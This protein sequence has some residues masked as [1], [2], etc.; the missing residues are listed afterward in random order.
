MNQPDFI[1]IG[2]G[3][4]GCILALRLARDFGATVTLIEAPSQPAPMID[5]ERPVRWMRLLESSE[6]W[7][8]STQPAKTLANR[9]LRWPRGRG[10]GGSSRINAM[11]WFPPTLADMTKLSAATNGYWSTDRIR[12]SLQA[13][14]DL[15]Q[16][17]KPGWLSLASQAFLDA[18]SKIPA[19]TP[20]AYQRIQNQGKRTSL[21]AILGYQ[22]DRVECASPFSASGQ[23]GSPQSIHYGIQVVRGLVNRI[24][25]RD[26]RAIGVTLETEQGKGEI[27]CN[28]GVILAAGS[29]S[30]PAI[31]MRSGVGSKELLNEIGIPIRND[32]PSVG[33]RLY[34]HLIMPVIFQQKQSRHQFSIQASP[35]DLSRWQMLGTGPLASNLAECGGLFLAN[36]I[37][38]HVTPTHYLTFPKLDDAAW[39]SIGVN[40]TQPKSHGHLRITSANPLDPPEIEAGYF[41]CEQD[42]ELMLQGIELTRE[43]ATMKSL[44]NL[45]DHESL[46]GDKRKSAQVLTRTIQ[47]FA[48][49][50]Y[51]PVGSCS[52]GTNETDV[53]DHRFRLRHSEGI[54]V[55]DGSVLPGIT[56]GNPSATI[57]SLAWMASEEIA[58][59]VE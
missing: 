27:S 37:Q 58:S 23:S 48:Q 44:D 21:A 14:T 8:F 22:E 34:D 56:L 19:A 42:F 51:H 26:N 52:V 12:Q 45:I 5:Q 38:L 20:M 29:I 41:N 13:V 40:V 28:R 59:S 24:R 2:A 3:S 39:M 30:T 4:A 54:W 32:L 25:W 55:V 46:P 31:L 50:L 1:V 11:I 43:L 47:R 9:R 17:E 18:A 53:V 7:N 15:I 16:P 35:R 6:D 36:K 49:T 10:I 57:M 33:Q